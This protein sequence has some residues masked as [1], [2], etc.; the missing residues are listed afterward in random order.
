VS[1]VICELWWKGWAHIHRLPVFGYI[2]DIFWI[3]FGFWIIF[4]VP[5]SLSLEDFVG[6]SEMK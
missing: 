6:Q 4:D 5:V 3:Y 2:L 1:D